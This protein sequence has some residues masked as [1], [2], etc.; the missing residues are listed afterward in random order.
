MRFSMLTGNAKWLDLSTD[1]IELQ[2][3][4]NVLVRDGI[5]LKRLEN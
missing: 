4:F 1:A 2:R 3:T 5:G